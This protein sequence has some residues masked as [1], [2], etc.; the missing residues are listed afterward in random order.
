MN[1]VAKEFVAS[2]TDGDGVLVL[3]EFAGAVV[4]AARGAPGEPVRHRGHGGQS[5]TAR[6]RWSPRSAGLGSRRCGPGW[7]TFD[8]H[9]WVASFL[10]QLERE[11]P[12]ADGAAG[13]P[14]AA[15]PRCATS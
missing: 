13:A 6:S 5:S 8:V 15:R 4:G 14:P 9:R 12:A 3:S 2:R 1:L 10:E 7:Q 11:S